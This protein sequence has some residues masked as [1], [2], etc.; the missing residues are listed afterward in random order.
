MGVDQERQLQTSIY[1]Y[2]YASV[3]NFIKLK[4]LIF[5]ETFS[6]GVIHSGKKLFMTPGK[7]LVCQYRGYK[8]HRLDPWAKKIPWRRSWQPTPVFLPGE[9]LGQRSLAGYSP[10]GCKRVGHNW[11]DLAHTHAHKWTHAHMCMCLCVCV[12]C[13][14]WR[15]VCSQYTYVL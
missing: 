6:N 3:D 14:K 5:L 1:P 15:L 9:S 13:Q 2:L 10:W 11:S 8:R 7:E 12:C 4:S